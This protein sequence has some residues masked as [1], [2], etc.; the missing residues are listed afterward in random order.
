MIDDDGWR[1]VADA[2]RGRLSDV[3]NDEDIDTLVANAMQ[4]TEQAIW[5]EIVAQLVEQGLPA[6]LE[7]TDQGPRL[8]IRSDEA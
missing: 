2:L 8:T 3:E 6:H 1:K 7:W 4:L 5:I